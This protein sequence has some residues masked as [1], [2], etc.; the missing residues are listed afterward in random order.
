LIYCL[1]HRLCLKQNFSIIKTQH[2]QSLP[3]Q[4]LCAHL[5][6]FR[7]SALHMVTAIDFND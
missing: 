1:Q 6:V 2:S 5:I 7:L 3:L 4:I